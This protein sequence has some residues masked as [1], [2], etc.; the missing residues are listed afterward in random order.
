MNLTFLYSAFALVSI[1]INLAAQDISLH[2]Y[3]GTYAIAFSIFCG[4]GAGLVTKYI[5]DKKFIFRYRP[6]V[7]KNDLY[8]FIKYTGTGVIT[9]FI[10]WGFEFGFELLFANKL[11]RYTGAVIG[12][13]I[14]YVIK[15]QLDKHL[16]FSTAGQQAS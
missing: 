13:T 1:I 7:L 11:A 14:G 5:L 8:T 4:T 10:F 12:L 3:S 15:Y 6:V 9:T 2:L 16:V